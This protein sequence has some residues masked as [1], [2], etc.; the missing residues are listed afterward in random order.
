MNSS[1]QQTADGR[2][3]I[4]V[5]KDANLWLIKINSHGSKLHINDSNTI[6][7]T[8]ALFANISIY[9]IL[10]PQSATTHLERHRS[11]L[12]SMIYWVNR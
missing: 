5:S 11:T 9:L 10:L 1:F 4:V 7:D 12:V 6:P 8:F 3:I 2:Y